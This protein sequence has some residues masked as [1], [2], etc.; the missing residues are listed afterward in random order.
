MHGLFTA[1]A[2]DHHLT[3]VALADSEFDIAES[4]EAMRSYSDEAT[5][6]PNPRGG[7]GIAKRLL[8]LRSLLSPRSF[9]RLR[10]AVPK[11]Q[12]RLD[13]LLRS[14]RFDVVQVEFPYLAHLRL[15][16]SPPG[17]PPP[18]LVVD[19]HEIAHEM[20][21]QFART[22]GGLARTAY[23]SLD[24]R[25]LRV[26]ELAAFRTSDGVAVCSAADRQRVLRDVP[27]AR[28][29]V[30][31]NAADVEHYRPRPG[32]PAPDGRT[33]VF[34]GLLSTLPNIDGVD[35]LVREI[36]PQVL[37]AR[38]DARLKILGK[39]ATAEVEALGGPTVEVVGFVS[40]LRP[41]LAAAA[42][43]VVPL[44]LGGGT[45]LKIVEAMA[46][47]RPVVSTTL[48]AEG[49]DAISGE[50]LVLADTP[51]TFAAEVVKLLED[52]RAGARLGAAARTL[53]EER[54]SWAG[55]AGALGSFYR[56]I[57]GGRT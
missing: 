24:W 36:W 21:R 48:G 14:R 57:L 9:E 38:P 6:L 2:R 17:T 33:V 46:M 11:L 56:E 7:G 43:I 51:P 18:V 8:Q 44:R 27:S 1:L 54:Y 22:G 41:H 39:D 20:V 45:R 53:V 28:T 37:Q 32:D 47:A 55:A 23:A 15:R 34:F 30:V 40:D 10:V 25:K 35:W 4:E 3:T 50:H 12:A 26:E 52:P 31:P 13:R 49:I 19:A 5:V 29:V 16:Q 42:A